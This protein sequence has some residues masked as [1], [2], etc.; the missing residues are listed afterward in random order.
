MRVEPTRPTFLL[1]SSFSLKHAHCPCFQGITVESGS[2]FPLFLREMLQGVGVLFPVLAVEGGDGDIFDRTFVQ[3]VDVDAVAVGVGAGDVEGFDAAGFAE[4]VPGGA[5]VELVFGERFPGG[6]EFEVCFGYDEV[7]KAGHGTDGA[8][9]GGGFD[10]CGGL[11][12]ELYLATM[13]ASGV[14]DEI[15]HGCIL[16]CQ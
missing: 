13:A 1:I 5:G 8:V 10:A 9:A 7:Q 6:E 11:H 3:A 2:L 12:L 16:F 4:E 15:F 14:G